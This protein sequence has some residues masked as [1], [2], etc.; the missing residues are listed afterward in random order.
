MGAFSTKKTLYGDTAKIPQVAEKIRQ[1]FV[2]E[3]YEVRIEDPASGQRIFIYRACQEAGKWIDEKY[4][5]Y[6]KKSS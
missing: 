3:G 2:N 5:E 6:K 1:A 4:Q